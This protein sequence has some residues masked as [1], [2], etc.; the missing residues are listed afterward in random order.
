[1]INPEEIEQKYFGV[2]TK[3]FNVARFASQFDVP[4]DLDAV[5][6]NM[7]AEDR[8]ILA[9]HHKV[10]ATAKAAWS[11]LDIYTATQALKN[12]LTG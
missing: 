7:A 10:M 4:D 3:V 6:A 12:F 9:E 8:W 11:E 1:H 5:P 2:L